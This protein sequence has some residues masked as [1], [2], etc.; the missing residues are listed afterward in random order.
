M[1]NHP[2]QNNILPIYR[3]VLSGALCVDIS[4]A[5]T[6]DTP[7]FLGGFWATVDYNTEVAE[8]E[9]VQKRTAAAELKRI[10][11]W[12]AGMELGT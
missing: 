6:M 8:K 12:Q 9:A 1:V 2:I 10:Q 11:E 3:P 4:L 7:L 5:I